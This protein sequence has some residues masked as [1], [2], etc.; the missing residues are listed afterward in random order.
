MNS[1]VL[2]ADKPLLMERVNKWFSYL[3]QVK[4]ENLYRYKGILNVKDTDYR[5]VFQGV[6][7]LFAGTEDRKWK[8][9]ENRKS[10][11]VFIGI[12]LN[13]DDLNKGFRYCMD[14]NLDLHKEGN[15]FG[16]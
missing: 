6:H 13:K 9:D 11:L 10:E 7:M 2:K 16:L 14:E 12:R 8:A 15:F 4:G 1:V 3:V 5:V